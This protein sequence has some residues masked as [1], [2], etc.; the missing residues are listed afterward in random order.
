M[1]TKNEMKLTQAECSYN[2]ARH[3]RNSQ[4]SELRGAI[5][6][7]SN[8]TDYYADNDDFMIDVRRRIKSWEHWQN[9]MESIKAE[10]FRL[11]IATG[12]RSEYL[13]N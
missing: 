9:K 6:A 4:E 13:G 1:S 7:R 8:G 2:N 11:C 5:A 3:Y 12:K 10:I